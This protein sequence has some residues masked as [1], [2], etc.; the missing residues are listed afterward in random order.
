MSITQILRRPTMV[1]AAPHCAPCN[2]LGVRE[3]KV[4]KPRIF[5]DGRDMLLSLGLILIIV[6][7]VIGS[8]GL[9][10]FNPGDPKDS[11][12]VVT[13]V[14]AQT[15]LRMETGTARYPIY[16]PKLADDWVPNSSRRVHIDAVKGS[17]ETVGSAVGWVH[18]KN[19]IEL[20]Q[21]GAP[22]EQIVAGLDGNDRPI[23]AQETIGTHTWTVYT[24][25][26][27]SIRPLW[28]S[29]AGQARW[30][31]TG[32]GPAADFRTV[33]EAM[34][35]ATLVQNGDS[36]ESSSSNSSTPEETS[37]AVSVAP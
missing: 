10:S 36:S 7:I 20:I 13:T 2:N 34:E 5:Q 6:V 16:L 17:E 35:G 29:D 18:A 4:E 30:V 32:I 27:K 1:H 9:C 15:F 3:T 33:A 11:G 22:V 24:A 23:T 25:E 28:I 8:T 19:W 14:D 21:T 26:D 37:V 31:L 12:K